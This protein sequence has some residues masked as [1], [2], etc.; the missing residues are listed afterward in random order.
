MTKGAD[1]SRRS[2]NGAKM[3]TSIREK[4]LYF[5]P[6]PLTSTHLYPH[7]PTLPCPSSL[8]LY[9]RQHGRLGMCFRGYGLRCLSGRDEGQSSVQLNRQNVTS[10]SLARIPRDKQLSENHDGSSDQPP[11]LVERES[12]DG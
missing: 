11:A 7:L 2:P 5:L 4:Q 3:S 8:A 1:A 6:R 12:S 9:S 10:V